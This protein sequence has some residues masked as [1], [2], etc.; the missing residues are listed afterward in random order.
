M[1]VVKADACASGALAHMIAMLGT[2]ERRGSR[3]CLLTMFTSFPS[4][5]CIPTAIPIVV[6]NSIVAKSYGGGLCSR[7]TASLHR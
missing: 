6:D 2:Q 7:A 3:A 5:T 1:W 4:C